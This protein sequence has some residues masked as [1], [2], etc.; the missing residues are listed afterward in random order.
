VLS[1][2]TTGT[3]PAVSGASAKP[4]AKAEA[5]AE[6]K[7]VASPVVMAPEVVI[8]PR[9]KRF[10]PS[11]SL[12]SLSCTFGSAPGLP[13]G[14]PSE[15]KMG[16]SFDLIARA[17]EYLEKESSIVRRIDNED[18]TK[19]MVMTQTKKFRA[20]EEGSRCVGVIIAGA[21]EEKQ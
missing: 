13:V 14:Y 11:R 15:Y 9:P 12:P 7:P 21:K 1:E 8:K 17:M 18:I 5:K 3:L 20:S 10:V 2:P 4:K 6:A 19:A 16:Q